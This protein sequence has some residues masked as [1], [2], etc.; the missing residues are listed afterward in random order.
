MSR[1]YRRFEIKMKGG[2]EMEQK[3][4]KV[5]KCQ[6]Q[7]CLFCWET[8]EPERTINQKC[9][10]CGDLNIKVESANK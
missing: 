6:N 8:N 5:I 9:L 10:V 3:E 1:K 4:L 2:L 7:H